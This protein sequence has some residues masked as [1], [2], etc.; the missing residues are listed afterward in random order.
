MVLYFSCIVVRQVVEFCSLPNRSEQGQAALKHRSIKSTHRQTIGYVRAST[1]DQT[2]TIDAQEA[3]IAAYCVAMGWPLSEVIR[4]PGRSAKSLE[5]PGM[6]KVLDAVRRGEVERVIVS[7][8]DRLTRSTRDLSDLLDLFAKTNTALVS[9]GETLDS[10]TA[11]GRMVV[12]MLG[13]VSQWEREAIGERTA[14]ALAHK[15][16]QG[17]AYGRTPFGFQRNGDALV[18]H[19]HHQAIKAEAVRMDR[20][21]HSFREIGSFLTAQTQRVWGPSTVRAMLRSKMAQEAT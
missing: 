16:S 8:L 3:R 21:G 19:P 11:S 7:K 18:A 9:I 5:R 13:V 10:S 12:N 17:Q 2:I 15:R 1:D 20:A 6:G 4:D 14:S